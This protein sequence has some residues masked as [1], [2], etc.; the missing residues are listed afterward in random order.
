[1]IDTDNNDFRPTT[2]GALTKGSEIIGAYNLGDLK[3]W[4]PGRKLYKTS[5]PIPKDEATVSYKRSHVICQTGYLAIQ[6]DFYFGESA[7]LVDSAEKGDKEFQLTLYNDENVFKLPPLHAFKVYYW[8][9]DV[10]KGGQIYKG[11]VW[12]FITI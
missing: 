8:R 4:I 1:M 6:H 2:D 9:V 5:N 3:Y 12:R 11:D 7:K 10:H